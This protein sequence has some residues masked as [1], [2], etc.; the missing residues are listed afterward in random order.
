MGWLK[1]IWHLI[2]T[3]LDPAGS[4]RNLIEEEVNS[5]PRQDVL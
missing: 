1:L 2:L 4:K 3:I 5:K